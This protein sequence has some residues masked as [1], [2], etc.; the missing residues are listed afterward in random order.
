MK[1]IFLLV[2]LSSLIINAQPPEK[3]LTDRFSG[4][5]IE[6][7]HLHLDRER[8]LAGETIWFKAYLSSDQLP[9]TISS[10]LYLELSNREGKLIQRRVLPI[11]AATSR[12]N[13]ELPDSLS[14][15]NY[16]IT[17]YTPQ[18][19]ETNAAFV[20]HQ[21]I[22]IHGNRNRTEP[23]FPS[24][25]NMEFFPEAGNFIEG[26]NNTIAFRISDGS[27]LPVDKKGKLLDDQ[28]NE[29]TRFESYHD[30]LGYFE[31][32][33]EKSR[34]YVA[35]IDSS[36]FE[37]PAA[38]EK[39]ILFSLV[40]HPQGSYFEIDQNKGEE[41]IRASFIIGQMQHQPVFRIE[42]SEDKEEL[43]GVINTL[44][45]PSGIMQVT[46]FNKQGFPL[47]E[48]LCFV[49]NH[50]YALNGELVFDTLDLRPR[51]KNHFLLKLKDTIQGSFSVSV[52]DAEFDS[53]PFREN[54]IYSRF[55]ISAD[56]PGYIP[57][58]AWY[59]RTSTDS[60]SIALDLLMMT[61]GWRRFKWVKLGKE[62][63]ARPAAPAKGFI[64]LEGRALLRD[65]KRSFADHALM[66]MIYDAS[67]KRIN[68]VVKTDNKGNFSVDS[69]VFYGK[70]RLIFSDIKG[71]K[72]VYL[73]IVLS[74]DSLF[75]IFDIPYAGSNWFNDPS[76]GPLNSFAND[77][78]AIQKASG[79]M[80]ENVTVKSVKKTP[81][82]ELEEKYTRG[83]FSSP[84]DKS[85]DLVSSN[86]AEIYPNIFDYLQS[87]V[88]G[89][90]VNRDGADYSLQYR[91]SASISSM[92]AFPM[93]LFLDE[94]ET[95]ASFISAIPA[96]QI[97]L[98]KIF[99]NFAASNGN[100]PG[101][102]L[103]IYTKKGNDYVSNKGSM[104]FGYY[105]GYSITKEFY[106]PDHLVREDARPDNR[107]T[108]DWR[109][110]IF[111][112]YVDPVL[113]FS[114]YNNDRTKKFRVVVEGMT[115]NG[116]LFSIEKIISKQ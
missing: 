11:V 63:P 51:A 20:F 35:V 113:P 61:N 19:A 110:D 76:P 91:Q 64:S 5:R 50:E 23:V 49:N 54:N 93:V 56:L 83:A 55:L 70:N 14:G 73:D 108:L 13:F 27:G 28:E 43:Q 77:L 30:G 65:S 8:Y 92:G 72:S 82:Q 96:S 104:S 74:K 99:P 114:F 44:S 59:L 21:K 1:T 79:L 18:M 42:L 58:P 17:A 9:D 71:K 103:A 109:P 40:P 97:A 107:I 60:A 7:I 111:C 112:N 34:K 10:S 15:G 38:I 101:G 16:L 84:T 32:T 80:L 53:T 106:V 47:A 85:I 69:L 62:I 88:N 4:N 24:A 25:I 94:V 66:V 100:A 26:K 105:E 98:V 95:D 48:R 6:K 31:L 115:T 81:I 75:R 39:G 29:I 86:E 116:K 45:L 67:K 57:D 68:Q 12:G 87:R 36:R 89:L 2:F 78:D 52:T 46:V 22:F 41:A 102:A 3:L 33:P 90:V 37:L